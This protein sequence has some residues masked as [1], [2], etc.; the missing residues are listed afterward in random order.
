MVVPV[1]LQLNPDA[2]PVS[3]VTVIADG[4]TEFAAGLGRRIEARPPTVVTSAR[5]CDAQLEAPP[6]L[7]SSPDA[8]L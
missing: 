7:L 8:W 4:T 2:A 6:P 3:S 5:T 1:V